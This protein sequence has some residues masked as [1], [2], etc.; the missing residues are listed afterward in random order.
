MKEGYE[1]QQHHFSTWS[2]LKYG[3]VNLLITLKLQPVS[4][5]GRLL[6]LHE[7][8]PSISFMA[9]ISAPGVRRPYRSKTSLNHIDMFS[10]VLESRACVT[11]HDRHGIAASN[12]FGSNVHAGL[13]L[14]K[15]L[16]DRGRGR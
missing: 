11:V 15:D 4:S 3:A 14:G 10:K 12:S 16:K 5:L 1:P 2:P 8:S 9:R 13:G 7:T 6:G